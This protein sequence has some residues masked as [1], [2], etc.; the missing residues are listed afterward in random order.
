VGAA[1]TAALEGGAGGLAGA[2]LAADAAAILRARAACRGRGE[3]ARVMADALADLADAR[4]AATLLV[5]AGKVPTSPPWIPG[6]RRWDAARLDHL[7]RSGAEPARLALAAGLE[8]PAA[9][10]ESAAGAERALEAARVRALRREARAR[11]LSL[12]VPLA[13]LAARREEVRRI[14][15]VLRGV[16]V[17]VEAD[18]LL[19]LVEA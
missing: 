1:A 4:N 9:A 10:L 12:A 6:G 8:V 14:A 11:P 2:E 7:A 5:L 16:A 15:L 17:G 19:D 18:E 13:Y 3:D